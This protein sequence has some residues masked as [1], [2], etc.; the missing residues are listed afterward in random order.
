MEIK[1][2]AKF[3]RTSP[4]KMRLVVNLVRG[5]DVDEAIIQLNFSKK[6]AA[7]P[8]SKLIKSAIANGAESDDLK[9]NN[10]FIKEIRVDEG[11]TLKRWMP[12]AM[13]RATPIRK[14]SSHIK[15]ILAEKVPTEKKE[16]VKPED[17]KDDIVKIEDLANLGSD[18]K[19]K[20]DKDKKGKPKD[21]NRGADSSKKGI[22]KIFN[23]TGNK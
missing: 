5:L 2:S 20:S 15:L 17:N 19:S 16:K 12:R 13:G 7:L 8:V 3:V 14:R 22:N 18:N 4:K 6:D 1:A 9:S 11:P 21:S 10:L 23:R